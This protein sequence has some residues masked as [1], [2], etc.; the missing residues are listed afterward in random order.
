VLAAIEKFRPLWWK[1][2]LGLARWCWLPGLAAI[3]YGLY[4]GDGEVLTIAACIWQFPLIAFGMA[5]LLVCALSPRLP[6]R[7]IEIPG[8]AFLA[9]IAYSVYLTHKLVIHAM[10]ELCSAHNIA[11]Q[12]LF[13]ILLV[14]ALVYVGGAILFL[15]VERPFLQ[16]RHRVVP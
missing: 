4:L 11:A 10:L 12:S 9:T 13:V 2:I 14:Q 15:A 3:T 8:A 6:F 5:T 16:L 7:R 1:P